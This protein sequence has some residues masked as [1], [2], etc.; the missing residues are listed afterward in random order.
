MLSAAGIISQN[1]DARIMMIAR[2][3]YPPHTVDNDLD[4]AEFVQGNNSNPRRG[5]PRLLRDIRAGRD[6]TRNLGQCNLT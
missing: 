6:V 5:V 2:P 1:I 4:V 3:S